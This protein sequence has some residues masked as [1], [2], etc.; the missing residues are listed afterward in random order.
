MKILIWVACFL[1]CAII[2]V[3]VKN[4]GIL[5]GGIPM[6]LLFG[7]T[8]FLAQT[9]CKAWDKH[10]FAKKE[11]NTTNKIERKP[12]VRLPFHRKIILILLAV[13]FVL[14]IA[15]L[16]GYNVCADNMRTAYNHYE[17]VFKR[18][19]T[20]GCGE[21]DCQFC[22]GKEAPVG[23]S[24]YGSPYRFAYYAN[25]S[26]ACTFFEGSGSVCL[27]LTGALLVLLIINIL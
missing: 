12:K 19:H 23:N 10:R 5:L 15:C 8:W 13:S 27:I 6:A 1:C 24:S 4:Q 11:E 3:I 7:A 18:Q 14:L 26:D 16:I 20:A 9:L 21:W 17:M 22:E 25:M 2:Q